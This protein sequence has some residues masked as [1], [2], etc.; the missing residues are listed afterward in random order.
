MTGM[1]IEWPDVPPGV[2]FTP[3]GEPLVLEGRELAAVLG[4]SDL[5]GLP[6]HEPGDPLW[7]MS[8]ADPGAPEGT[9]FLG[10]VIIQAPS[11][12][13]AVTRSHQAGVNPGGEIAV[14]GPIPPELIGAEWRDRL[15]TRDEAEAIPEPDVNDQFGWE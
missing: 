13:A 4:V 15:L 10:V 7:W 2:T 8:F 9:Q 5:R 1:T 6:D 12:P 14:A 11:C 3:V